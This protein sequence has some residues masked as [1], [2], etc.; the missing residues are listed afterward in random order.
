MIF[1]N[2]VTVVG[3]ALCMS[4]PIF[5]APHTSDPVKYSALVFFLAGL[6]SAIPAATFRAALWGMLPAVLLPFLILTD[7][8]SGHAGKGDAGL[9]DGFALLG[10]IGL[11]ACTLVGIGFGHTFGEVVWGKPSDH[12]LGPQIIKRRTKAAVVIGAIGLIVLMIFSKS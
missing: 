5:R 2:S 4:I 12:A 8:N 6:A 7:L 3:I 1:A 10:S 9:A 11:V